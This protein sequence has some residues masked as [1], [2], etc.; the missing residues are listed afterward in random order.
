MQG[1]DTLPAEWAPRSRPWRLH[2]G[3]RDG[4]HCRH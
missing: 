2:S 1:S 4:W 3:W